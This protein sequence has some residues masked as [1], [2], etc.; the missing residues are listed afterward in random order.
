MTAP[1]APSAPPPTALLPTT[2]EIVWDDELTAYDHGPG[3]PLRPVRL[4]LTMALARQ[5]GVLDRPGVSF[6]S[7][8]TAGDDL[9]ALVHDP[10]YVSYVKKVTRDQ[11]I[12]ASARRFGFASAD[13]PV[14][15]RMH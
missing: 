13:N 5:L 4:E 7:P 3:H 10:A 8:T 6:R 9:L 15:D 12:D 2:V 14:F 11:L 1:S